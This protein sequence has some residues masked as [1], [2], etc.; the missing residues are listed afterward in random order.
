[1]RKISYRSSDDKMLQAPRDLPVISVKRN[2]NTESDTSGFTHTQRSDLERGESVLDGQQFSKTPET[3]EV[4][5]NSG[6]NIEDIADMLSNLADDLELSGD[7]NDLALASFSHFLIKKLG[8]AK[9]FSYDKKL[10]E[11]MIKISQS[12]LPN[13]NNLLLHLVRLFNE[14]YLHNLNS[15]HNKFDSKRLSYDDVIKVAEQYASLPTYSNVRIAQDLSSSPQFVADKI[16]DVISVMVNR[17]SIKSRPGAYKSI[18]EKLKNF[19]VIDI[20]NKNSP[21]G[22]SIGVSLS[23]IKNILNGRD[24]HFIKMVIDELLNKLK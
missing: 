7:Y 24:G 10:N 3:E 6:V 14:K 4:H 9:H 2:S 20:A 17:M 13:I 8:S 21:G 16:Y 18:G 22:A 23:L 19:N 15:G 5:D 11:L 1:M 12:D